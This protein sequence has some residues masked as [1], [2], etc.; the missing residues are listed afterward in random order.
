[1]ETIYAKESKQQ[2]MKNYLTNSIEVAGLKAR[3]DSEVK[4]LLSDKKV[5]SWIMK[6]TAE[7]FTDCTIE[8]IMELIEGKPIV[9]EIPVYPGK[10]PEAITGMPTSDKV[11]NEGEITF[12]IRFH[13]RTPDGKHLKMLIN[14]TLKKY[15][16]SGSAWS[17]PNMQEIQLRNTTLNRKNYMVI[18]KEKRGMI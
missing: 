16:A 4:K 2:F 15:I 12:D 9:S 17:R 11:P 10:T 13:I 3:Y 5:L 18:L 7:E 6:H 8:E 1:M 14:T